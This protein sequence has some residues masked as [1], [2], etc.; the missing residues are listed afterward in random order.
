MRTLRLTVAYDGTRYLGWQWQPYGPTI[1]GELQQAVLRLT[2]E[3]VDVIGSGRTGAGVHALGQ[4]ANFRTQSSLPLERFL[5]GLTYYLPNDIV[6]RSVAEAPIDFH[7]QY[8]A[9]KKRYRYLITDAPAEMP[10]LLPYVWHVR[11]PL[12]TTAMHAAGQVLVGRHDFRCFETKWPNKATS[13]RTVMELTVRRESLWPGW[14]APSVASSDAVRGQ[15]RPE[16]DEG[17]FIC[18]E[19]VADGFLWNMVR[20]ITGTLVKVGFGQWTAND[21][22]RILEQGDRRKAGETAPAHG[23]YLVNVDYSDA[24]T[25]G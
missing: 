16:Q 7:A 15:P 14:N 23:L 17:R 8:Q 9:K 6:V 5:H 20:A 3:S 18:L 25:I 13:V 2:G 12:C 24:Q 22:Q 4:V 11:R 10:F 1:Q 21:V 19:I